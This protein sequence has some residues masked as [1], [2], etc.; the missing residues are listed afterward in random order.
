M[1]GRLTLCEVDERLAPGEPRAQLVP[2]RDVVLAKPPAQAH[3]APIDERR[4]VD[5]ARLDLAQRDAQRI[6]AG[7]TGLHLV[8]DALHPKA[9][10]PKLV[11]GGGVVRIGRAFH[12][13]S[14]TGFDSLLALEDLVA[15]PDQLSPLVAPI[16][17]AVQPLFSTWIYSCPEGPRH[18]ND[19]LEE[20]GGTTAV[21]K[22]WFRS[23]HEPFVPRSPRFTVP[24]AA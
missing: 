20:Y 3:L 9:D 24:F 15:E 10:Q 17:V 14:A 4:K 21:V 13:A 6:D 19:R 1:A 5:E 22:S 23:L 7:D 2:P 18:L 16:K 12:H 11:V 8:D